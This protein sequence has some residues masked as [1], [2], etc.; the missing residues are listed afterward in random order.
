M[1]R[2][3][4]VAALCFIFLAAPLRASC[5]SSSCPLDLNVLNQPLKDHF[6][7]DLSLQYIDQDQPRIGR[8]D[9]HVGEIPGE[10]HD[11]V[12]TINRIAAMFGVTRQRIS[13]LLREA[14][15]HDPPG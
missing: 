7:L 10:H 3:L 8:H 5:G 6:T 12:R 2:R 13:A 9:A 11:E 4:S 15:E 14:G 1:S